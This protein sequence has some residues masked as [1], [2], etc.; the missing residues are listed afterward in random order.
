MNSVKNSI[1]FLGRDKKH[2]FDLMSCATSHFTEFSHGL[3]VAAYAI[4]LAKQNGIKAYNQISAIGIASI[5]HD[6]GKSKIDSKILE[7]EGK[8]TSEERKLVERHP[9]FSYEIVHRAGVIPP[10]SEMVIL[11][12]HER[13]SGRG[14]P[15]GISG[16]LHAFSKIVALCDTFDLLTSDR[17]YKTAL[18]PSEAIDYLRTR[19]REDF[20]QDLVTDF[21][22]M[23]RK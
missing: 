8:L 2:F 17:P 18:K 4:M 21:I 12:H 10:L 22:K 16:D 5:L 23:L 19:G 3:H 6:I 1:S 20:D 14:Y 7:K 9:V 11:Q 13:P 15:A